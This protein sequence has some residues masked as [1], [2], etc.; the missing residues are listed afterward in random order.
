MINPDNQYK[1]MVQKSLEIV[2]GF[3]PINS[4]SRTLS[5]RNL[6]AKE[7]PGAN[8]IATQKDTKM[9]G[10]TLASSIRRPYS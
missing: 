6:R 5:V 9:K 8:S 2:R 10:R 1:M 7:N 3:F 4:R